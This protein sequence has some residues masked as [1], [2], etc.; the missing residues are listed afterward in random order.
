[1]NDIIE[2][3]CG[4][5]GLEM[6]RLINEIIKPP[7]N[8]PSLSFPTDSACVQA[9][10]QYL[11]FTTDSHIIDPIIFPGGDIG[12][13]AV[14]GTAN[15][16][17]V[18]GGRPLYMSLGLLIE[19]GLKTDTL[20]LV[21]ESVKR[22]AEHIGLS[23]VTGD[24]KVL[25]KGKGDK[26]FINTSC[27]GLPVFDPVCHF[28]NI[29]PG[30]VIILTGGIAEHGIAVMMQREGISLDSPVRSD[31]R[32]LHEV[33]YSLAEKAVT[34]KFMTDPTRGG[35]SSALNEI[36]SASGLGVVLDETCVPVN[37]S[38]L[39]VCEILGLNPYEIAC[40]GNAVIITDKFDAGKAL[41]T[42]RNCGD[43][44]KNAAIIGEIKEKPAGR[45]IVHTR[46]GTDVL[47]SMPE[48]LN[49]PRI[50]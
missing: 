30:D 48:G 32:S 41:E 40:E 17:L 16:I 39:S 24:T 7:I 49:L 35:L 14:C 38:V 18:A 29:R 27:I 37:P 26:I 11:L 25:E 12:K 47:L 45:V 42:I 9:R 4:N 22:E 43:A 2:L 15:D 36:A 10:D 8:N 33:V 28:R 46:V 31:V 19:E 21:M 23:I 5:G 13:L 34:P 1:M 20:R 44:G 3:A 6:H 50:C